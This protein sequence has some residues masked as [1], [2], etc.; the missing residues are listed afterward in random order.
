MVI[1]T[2]I[3]SI[4]CFSLWK[5]FN[6]DLDFCPDRTQEQE[7]QRK[8]KNSLYPFQRPRPPFSSFDLPLLRSSVMKAS[9]LL[10]LILLLLFPFEKSCQEKEEE[11]EQNWVSHPPTPHLILSRHEK[12]EGERAI[13]G[14]FPLAFLGGG[15]EGE[16]GRDWWGLGKQQLFVPLPP[17]PPSFSKAESGRGQRMTKKE[18]LIGRN[19]FFE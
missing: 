6:F 12:G 17:P 4:T 9:F 18:F 13:W 1:F 11:E 7:K 3:A 8:C 5:V 2:R 10:P 14:S 16:R 15:G 19:S